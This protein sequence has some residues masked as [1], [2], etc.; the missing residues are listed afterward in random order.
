MSLPLKSLLYLTVFIEGYVILA[1]EVLAI[2]QTIPYVGSGTETVSIII[3][4]VLMPLAAGYYTGGQYRPPGKSKIIRSY[5]DK[6]I[7]NIVAAGFILL[8]GQSYTVIQ[9][10]FEFLYTFSYSR[11]LYASIY[12]VLFLVIPVFLLGQTVP[13]ISNYFSREDISK[14]TGKILFFSTA[15]SFAGAVFSTVVLMSLLGVHHTA[16]IGFL[17]L[18]LIVVLLSKKPLGLMTVSMG[19][20]ALASLWM[21]S[22]YVMKQNDIVEN[23]QYSTV[24]VLETSEGVRKFIINQNLSSRLE[25]DGTVSPY[26]EFLERTYIRYAGREK[27]P[28]RILVLG[29]GGFSLGLKDDLNHYDFVDIDGSLKDIAEKYFL[30]EK[31]SQ[32]KKFHSMP[33]RAYLQTNKEP[34]DI[35]F[36]D[37]YLGYATIPEHLVTKEFFMQVKKS[38]APGG[39]MVANFAVSPTFSTPFSRHLDDTLHAVFPHLG[40]Q[41]ATPYIGRGYK[42]ARQEPRKNVLYIYHKRD[43]AEGAQIYTDD[44]NRS[45]LDKR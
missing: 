44:K 45:F 18:F 9:A 23:N 30:K 33:A 7:F 6:L 31:L 16:S 8:F 41:V 2:R 37:T 35:I 22:G 40:R 17:L 36:L 25:Q 28:L 14:A 10:L 20:I 32:N 15:G 29:A 13:L 26:V 21:N 4:A 1:A 27:D 24:R 3:A 5:R 42:N 39:V 43:E 19:C 11:L 12:S 34:Y 38:M